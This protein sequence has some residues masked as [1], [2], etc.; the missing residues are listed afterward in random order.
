MKEKYY[1]DQLLVENCLFLSHYL[2]CFGAI[3]SFLLCF[4]NLRYFITNLVEEIL[5][6]TQVIFMGAKGSTNVGALICKGAI[7]YNS[8]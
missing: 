3:H 4:F 7:L 6:M 2:K 5:N 8:L 1:L